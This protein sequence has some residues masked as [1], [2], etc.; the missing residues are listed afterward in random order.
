MAVDNPSPSERL[1]QAWR[2]V[3]V[4]RLTPAQAMAK[5]GFGSRQL[6]SNYVSK[7]VTLGYIY[8]RNDLPEWSRWEDTYP[9]EPTG[10]PFQWTP[11]PD[12]AKLRLTWPAETQGDLTVP[13]IR[14]VRWGDW[15]VQ[16]VPVLRLDGS[17]GRS[18]RPPD[19]KTP[20][21]RV[22]VISNVTEV[23]DPPT[24]DDGIVF[25]ASVRDRWHESD[26]GTYAGPF[27]DPVGM[28]RVIACALGVEAVIDVSEPE[29][30]HTTRGGS[31]DGGS[32]A[33]G[34]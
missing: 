26:T 18:G 9:Y 30:T 24:M 6:F 25:L 12:Q 1:A 5:Y 13:T 15:L 34:D 16:G 10:K 17:T 29:R 7:L 33:P 2:A 32:A 19:D 14:A 27:D 23:A 3:V 31:D 21:L 28:T 11:V 20:N 22:V 8:R 4:E